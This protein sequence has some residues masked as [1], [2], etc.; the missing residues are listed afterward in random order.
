MKLYHGSNVKIR[1]IDL[2]LCRDYKDFGKG[3]YLTQD[4]SRA[5]NMANYR[6]DLEDDGSPEISPFIFNKARCHPD[7]KIK[8][9]KTR[10]WEWAR[11]V[12]MNR[13]RS[14]N[15]PYLHEYDIVIG[16]VADSHVDDQIAEYKSR[17]PHNYN[18]PDKLTELALLLRYP[19]TDYIQ[20]CFCT[21]RAV[22]ELI[23]D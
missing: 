15:P 4:Y 2:S 21:Q 12:M 17:Y 18:D 13:D 1:E 20:Y 11:F 22:D 19:G 23:S 10:N 8:E 7:I 6:K 3:F 5:V 16:P 9:F 14:Q